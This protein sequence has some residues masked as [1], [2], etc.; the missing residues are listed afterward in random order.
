MRKHVVVGLFTVLVLSGCVSETKISGQE[1]EQLHYQAAMVGAAYW[2]AS[3]CGVP[4]AAELNYYYKNYLVKKYGLMQTATL[5]AL[6]VYEFY[7]K[8]NTA[9]KPDCM[10]AQKYTQASV[11]MFKDETEK[12]E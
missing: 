2:M 11:K 10:N 6:K 4:E 7:S 5:D 9:Q 1:K 8:G 3:S 12:T